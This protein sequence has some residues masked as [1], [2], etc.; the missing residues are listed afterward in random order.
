MGRDARAV[1]NQTFE[2]P[3]IKPGNSK[4]ILGAQAELWS[5]RIL[6][7]ADVEYAAFPRSTAL[8]EALWTPLAEKDFADF[9]RRLGA[10]ARRWER[11][12]PPVNYHYL[13][14]PP[15]EHWTPA[16]ISSNHGLMEIAVGAPEDIKAV[17]SGSCGL[18]FQY[19]KGSQ[20]LSIHKVE[21][22]VDG[23]VIAAD[24]HEGFTGNQNRRNIYYLCP[25]AGANIPSSAKITL[26]V[27]AEAK[28]VDS[29]GDIT[30][31]GSNLLAKF[32]AD[33]PP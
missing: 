32:P 5:E 22:V 29:S 10:M 12:S 11:F 19:S 8:A 2:Y 23:S 27:T 18:L 3:E 28:G 16:T 26:R 13:T 25:P 15:F 30:L 9:S 33:S 24:S 17:T 14:P 21:L 6:K 7:P 20:G 31:L 4:H 1:Y